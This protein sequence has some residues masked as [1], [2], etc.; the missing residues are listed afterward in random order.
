MHTLL[1]KTNPHP[2]KPWEFSTCF[3][4][5]PQQINPLQHFY[6][7]P[8][9]GFGGRPLSYLH[10]PPARWHQAD[11]WSLGCVFLEMAT[12]EKPWGNGAFEN[13]AWMR[14]PSSTAS[15]MGRL[16]YFLR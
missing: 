4:L 15:P 11:I 16:V 7:N 9:V 10:L 6:Q 3:F 1:K 2:T 14:K 8:L 12:A 13:V 5:G